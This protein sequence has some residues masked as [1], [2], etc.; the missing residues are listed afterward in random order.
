MLRSRLLLVLCLALITSCARLHLDDRLSTLERE[1]Q[2]RQAKLSELDVQ[3]SSAEQR[4]AEAQADALYQECRAAR[5]RLEAEIEIAKADCMRAIAERGACVAKNESRTT[6]GAGLGCA[7]GWA[8]A[9][10]TGGAAAPAVLVGCAGGA[11]I[12]HTT[13]RECGEVPACAAREDLPSNVLRKHGHS[14]LPV[15]QRKTVQVQV[16]ESWPA[17][18]QPSKSM[19]PPEPEGA[20]DAWRIEWVDFVSPHEKHD[21]K[22]WDN[23]GS[24][25]DLV[26]TIHVDGHRSYRSPKYEAFQ[27][28]HAPQATILVSPGQDLSIDLVDW[29]IG[30][31]E[32]VASFRG[33]V[34]Q[35][36][37]SE[38]LTLTSGRAAARVRFACSDE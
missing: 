21:G 12:S 26:Y 25:P 5:T 11:A 23:N 8:A 17:G 16:A 35:N 3:I 37:P 24:E 10:L 34:P 13:R 28:K 33:K 6:K 1:E 27:W 30:G 32:R 20:C 31:N 4:V 15:C 36:V 14:A 22:A 7:A 9:F 18:S 38:D 29:D 19:L 2:R